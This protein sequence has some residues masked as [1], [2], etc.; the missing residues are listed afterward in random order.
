MVRYTFAQDEII[1]IQEFLAESWKH[2]EGIDDS[3]TIRDSLEN[4]LKQSGYITTTA[5]YP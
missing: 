3:K 4:H 2:L 1:V 5:W